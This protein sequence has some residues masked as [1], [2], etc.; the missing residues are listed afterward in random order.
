MSEESR[1]DKAAKK[2]VAVAAA[3]SMLVSGLFSPPADLPDDEDLLGQPPA[4]V[5]LLLPEPEPFLDPVEEPEPEE[6]KR[7]LSL[8]ARIAVF[9]GI[10]IAAAIAISVIA[11]LLAALPAIAAGI[12]RFAAT[13]LVIALAGVGAM[14]LLFPEK[15]LKELLSRNNLLKVVAVCVLSGLLCAGTGILLP[16]RRVLRGLL[17][18]ILA[19]LPP[20]VAIIAEKLGKGAEKHPENP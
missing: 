11:S 6:K 4:I 1:K 3:A 9:A 17:C 13:A 19:L 5:E 20:A 7:R 8:P 14:K 2:A 16:E 12:L 10:W 18:P 15:S